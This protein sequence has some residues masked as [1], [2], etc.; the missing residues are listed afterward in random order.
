[1]YETHVGVLRIDRE[2]QFGQHR[3]DGIRAGV[4]IAVAHSIGHMES[5][6]CNLH[7]SPRTRHESLTEAVVAPVVL[8]GP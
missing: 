5:H 2:V 8:R 6:R 4:D 7:A 1:M 3:I